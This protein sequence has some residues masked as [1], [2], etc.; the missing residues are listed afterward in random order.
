MAQNYLS[1]TKVLKVKD[2][3]SAATSDVTS[4]IVDTA[5]FEGVVFVTSF[6]TAN[7]TNVMKLQQ[8]TA[9]Q[10]TGMADL[11][12]SAVSSGS[13]DEDV[14]IELHRPQERYV[15]AVIARGA[16]TAVEAVWAFLYGQGGQIAA[17]SVSGTQVAK[18]LVSPPEGTA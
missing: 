14:I 6:S 15:Q 4:D 10:T 17:N 3:A 13:S 12:G 5:G 7:A 9:N 18:V 16:S 8:N 2:Q 11:A 1:R